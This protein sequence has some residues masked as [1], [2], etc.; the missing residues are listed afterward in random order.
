MKRAIV[1]AVV[2]LFVAGCIA[3]SVWQFSR[4]AEVRERNAVLLSRG[5]LPVSDILDVDE[6]IEYRRVR[7]RGTYDVEREIVV[8]SQSYRGIAGNHVVTPLVLADGR[9]VLVNRGWVPLIYDEPGVAEAAPA[10]R[11]VSVEGTLQPGAQP[12]RFAPAFPPEGPYDVVPRLELGRLAAQFPYELVQ[13]TLQLTGQSPEQTGEFPVAQPPPA[14]DRGPHTAYAIQ[15]LLF[16][17]AA[18]VTYVL[19]RRQRARREAIAND[20]SVASESQ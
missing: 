12:G 2:G 8:R 17:L 3:A 18:L 19:A 6:P 10:A 5:E 14:L 15:W 1:P 9:A 20:T 13:A 4:A 7:A 11:A 16:A